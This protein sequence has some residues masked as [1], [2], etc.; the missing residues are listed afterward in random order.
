MINKYYSRK[1]NPLN[2]KVKKF[3]T[4]F[5]RNRIL[6]DIQKSWIASI[7]LQDNDY[8]EFTLLSLFPFRQ[9]IVSF[10]W[11]LM[12][13]D[14]KFCSNKQA[15]LWISF[16]LAIL[17]IKRLITLFF[18]DKL[19]SVRS[20]VYSKKTIN[21]TELEMSIQWKNMF[22]EYSLDN[23][24]NRLQE[25][26]IQ[27]KIYNFEHNFLGWRISSRSCVEFHHGTGKATFFLISSQV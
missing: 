11:R 24:C 26:M 7:R 20:N 6:N 14:E 2:I 8:N 4:L 25:W 5:W 16:N 9:K 15:W 1:C 13:V 21:N 22:H 3:P 19:L 10:T 27:L 23:Q 18:S 17:L 12:S